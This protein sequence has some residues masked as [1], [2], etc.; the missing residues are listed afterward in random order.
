[1]RVTDYLAE[2]VCQEGVRHVFMGSGGGMMF[3]S[4]GIALQRGL[5]PV[6]CHHEQ[7]AAMAAVSYAKYTGNLGVC[8]V[9]TGCGGTNAVTGLLHAWQDSV[10]TLFVSG[11]IKRAQTIRNSGLALRQFGP[12]E[13][14]ILSVVEPLTKYAAMLNDPE[15]VAWQ[16]D[17]ALYLARC[18]R[19]GPVWLDVPLDVQGAPVRP[20][21]LARFGPDDQDRQNPAPTPDALAEVAELLRRAE[22][23]IIVAGQGIRLAKAIPAFRAFVEKWQI[24]VVGT[25][26]TVDILPSAHPLF[27]GRIGT[28]GDRP[29]NLAMQNSD[30]LLSIGCR[31]GVNHTG[32]EYALFARAATIVVVDVDPVEHQKHTIRIDRFIHADARRFVEA[33]LGVAPPPPRAAWVEKCGHW[34][35]TYPVCLP[36]HADDSR[37]VNS[38]Y[39]VQCL[40]RALK[41]DAVVISDAGS[42]IDVTA[43]ALQLREGQ[44]YIA[45]GGQAEMGYSLPAAIG[46]SSARDKG[47]VVVVTGDGSLQLN[48][49]DLVTIA[50]RGLP[51][52]FFVLNNGG[53]L[54][55]RSTQRRF[56]EG[57]HI[58]TDPASGLFFPDLE[59]IAAAYG[60]RY[61]RLDHSRDLPD[62]IRDVLDHP[63][64][65]L[66]EVIGVRDQD[67]VPRVSSA[68]RPDGSLVSKPLE[69][70]FPFLDRDEFRREMIVEPL[71]E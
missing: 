22:R 57:R 20:E 62:R 17:Q 33:I 12:Q 36:E 18:G 53:Y 55:I 70:M 28:R 31:M 54:S 68:L 71:D 27:I 61:V 52:K 42:S 29:G 34:K 25:R 51:V 15:Q 16:L 63:G 38:Y 7:V 69:D 39:L 24:P 13:G 10:P 58:G 66:G 9:T 56:F 49:Q 26:L 35:A 37:G 50:A 30:L 64:P 60:I 1:M 5:E 67:I 6:C 21:D 44:R 65:V 8:Y 40:C 2:R 48:I 14:N 59:K 11:Q 45:S 46:V 4:D 47:E 32:H 19:P 43:Q 41:D 3:L 23:P